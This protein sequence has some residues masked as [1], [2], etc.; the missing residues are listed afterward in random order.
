MALSTGS[1]LADYLVPAPVSRT[2]TLLRDAILVIGSSIFLAV[3]A[4][5][6]IHLPPITPVAFTLQTLA[7]V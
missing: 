4:Q 5:I 1:T 2:S 7:V 3:C 6:S